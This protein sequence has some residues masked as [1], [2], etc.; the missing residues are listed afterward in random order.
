VPRL[1]EP[2]ASTRMDAHGPGWAR[3]WPGIVRGTGLILARNR[4]EARGAVFEVML[5]RRAAGYAER[6]GPGA[7][8]G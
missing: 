1:F 3:R 2:F 7:H 6:E 5:P 8:N 4:A